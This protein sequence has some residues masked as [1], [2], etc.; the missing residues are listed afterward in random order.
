MTDDAPFNCAS[1]VHV[2]LHCE[3][4]TDKLVIGTFAI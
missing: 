3:S 2:T 1:Y 4:W